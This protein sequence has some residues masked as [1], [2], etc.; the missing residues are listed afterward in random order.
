MHD[1]TPVKEFARH[2]LDRTTWPEINHA[3]QFRAAGYYGVALSSGKWHELHSWLKTHYPNRYCWTGSIFWFD[4]ER[5][6][7]DVALRWA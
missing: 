1:I 2:Y 7:T 5:I 4:D 6:A 3:E